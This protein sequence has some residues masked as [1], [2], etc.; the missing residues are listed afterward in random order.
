MSG[1]DGDVCHVNISVVGKR[2]RCA[3]KETT[4]KRGAHDRIRENGE[5]RGLK[6]INLE[7]RKGITASAWLVQSSWPEAVKT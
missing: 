4:H 7:T 6:N 3:T 5:W 2:A 1:C